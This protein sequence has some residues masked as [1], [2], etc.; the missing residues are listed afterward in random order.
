MT[1]TWRAQLLILLAALAGL[2]ACSREYIHEPWMGGR[3]EQVKQKWESPPA[4]HR[5]D[6]MRTRLLMTQSDH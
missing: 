5:D 1:I 6:E 3:G 4:P 2:S